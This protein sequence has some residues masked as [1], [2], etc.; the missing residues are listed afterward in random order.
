MG[1]MTEL[2]KAGKV[3]TSALRRPRPIPSAGRMRFHLSPPSRT[4]TRCGRASWS[5][6]RFMGESFSRN[7]ELVSVI[8]GL[9][10]DKGVTPAQLA[11]A[12]GL[13]KS[14]DIV[15]QCAA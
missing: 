2:V 10:R 7:L 8:E 12:W 1:A 9:A 11:Y 3:P 15:P 13:A 4:N 5:T 6:A 14:E